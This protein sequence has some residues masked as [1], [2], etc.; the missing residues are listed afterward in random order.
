MSETP[1]DRLEAR[2]LGGALWVEGSAGDTAFVPAGQ[3]DLGAGERCDQGVCIPPCQNACTPGA[4]QCSNGR[5]QSC[6]Q[7]PAGCFIWRDEPVCGA[8]QQCLS[9]KCRTACTS[10]ELETWVWPCSSK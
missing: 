2:V 5:P 9:G 1:V 10:G 3:C 6:E 7:G 8:D 4:G